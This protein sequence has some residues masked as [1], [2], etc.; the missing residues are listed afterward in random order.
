MESCTLP[1][2]ASTEFVMVSPH[3]SPTIIRAAPPLP[4]SDSLATFD[5]CDGDG[6]AAA[7]CVVACPSPLESNTYVE[8]ASAATPSTA[9]ASPP[10]VLL[11][12]DHAGAQYDGGANSTEE[13]RT[14]AALPRACGDALALEANF[15]G[16]DLMSET[17]LRAALPTEGRILLPARWDGQVPVNPHDH[18]LGLEEYLQNELRNVTNVVSQCIPAITR[19]GGAALGFA[20]GLFDDARGVGDGE[21]LRGHGIGLFGRTTFAAPSAGGSTAVHVDCFVPTFMDLGMVATGC[22]YTLEHASAATSSL[23]PS[24]D[25]EAGSNA[26]L[27]VEGDA[28]PNGFDLVD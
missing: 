15:A 28:A 13:L 24:A 27:S 14:V 19:V 1:Q 17:I 26:G 3:G 25:Y 6:K 8:L 4:A 2:S 10:A 12:D 22:A 16:S 18:D 21:E 11:A 7:A 5:T 9:A 23:T 20:Q